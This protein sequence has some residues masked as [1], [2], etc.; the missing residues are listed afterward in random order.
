[1]T[2]AVPTATL[3][4]TRPSVPPSAE[5]TL[6]AASTLITSDAD[7]LEENETAALVKVAR[8]TAYESMDPSPLKTANKDRTL[9]TANP[10]LDN[11]HL[12]QNRDFR[13]KI[14]N[15][16]QHTLACALIYHA[17]AWCHDHGCID[18]MVH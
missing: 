2:T 12:P 4:D 5:C 6:V 8:Y 18:S 3:T 1:M 9:A 13:G 10:V 17:A 7:K 14:E 11:P 16:T 15:Q